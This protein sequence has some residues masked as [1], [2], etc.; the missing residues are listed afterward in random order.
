MSKICHYLPKTVLLD[1]YFA[2][3]HLHLFYGIAVW[4]YTYQNLINKFQIL[5]NKA[6]KIIEGRDWNSKVSYICLKHKILIVQNLYLFEIGKLMYR[7]HNNRLPNTFLNY[8]TVI[9]LSSKYKTHAFTADTNR[10][11]LFL[12]N[13]LQH[14]IK[15]QGAKFWNQI[16]IEIKKKVLFEI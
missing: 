16:P 8:F 14:S 7:F 10:L 4:D 11:P 9:S 1:F 2:F 13:K 12:T 5:Q 15:F 3:I 6:M